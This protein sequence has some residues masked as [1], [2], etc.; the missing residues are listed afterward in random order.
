[1]AHI[2]PDKK[3]NGFETFFFGE[4]FGV[5][6]M[7]RD[8]LS[9][10]L[11]LEGDECRLHAKR[12]VTLPD[13]RTIVQG[14][15]I[16]RKDCGANRPVQETCVFAIPEENSEFALRFKASTIRVAFDRAM[17]ALDR[18]CSTPDLI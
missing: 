9:T 4:A 11:E 10:K 13:K 12:A 14:I 18:C 6:D 15:L 2:R 1:M 5:V 8:L 17:K 3:M 7:R 16:E